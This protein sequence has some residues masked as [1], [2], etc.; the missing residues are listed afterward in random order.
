[1][2]SRSTGC[3]A[4]TT[5]RCGR[6]SRPPP[7]RDVALDQLLVEPLQPLDHRAPALGQPAA[8]DR[9]RRDDAGEGAGDERLVGA[10]D[11]GE[12]EILLEHRD[13]VFA[14]DADNV[15]ARDAAEQ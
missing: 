7:L 6:S 4:P 5:W 9:V 13:A 8:V 14:A 12:R 2:S 15:A 1:A 10:I 11:V 3:A